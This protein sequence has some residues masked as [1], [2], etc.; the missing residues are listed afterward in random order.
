[1]RR[2]TATGAVGVCLALA[3]CGSTHSAGA[4]HTAAQPARSSTALAQATALCA[5]AQREINV[6]LRHGVD[7]SPTVLPTEIPRT[8]RE[9]LPVIDALVPKLRRIGGDDPPVRLAL[10]DTDA[11]RSALAKLAKR[12]LV[13]AQSG[14]HAIYNSDAACVRPRIGN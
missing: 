12:H 10:R 7:P 1:M 8:A 14:M 11:N 3:G 13:G 6:I 4:T 5:E 9:S 2:T